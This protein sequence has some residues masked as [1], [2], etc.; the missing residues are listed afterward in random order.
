MGTAHLFLTL[1]TLI[2][3]PTDN[4]SAPTSSEETTSEDEAASLELDLQGLNLIESRLLTLLEQASSAADTDRRG[5][6]AKHP[7]HRPP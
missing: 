4:A 2:P 7:R 5:S 6:S 1:L 3:L